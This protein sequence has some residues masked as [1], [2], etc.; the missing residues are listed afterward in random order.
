MLC[1]CRCHATAPV[2]CC[3]RSTST[4]NWSRGLKFVQRINH[5]HLF[6]P[7]HCIR[8]KIRTSSHLIFESCLPNQKRLWNWEFVK[9]KFR[10]LLSLL[11]QP[12]NSVG[13][14]SFTL[15]D[16]DDSNS[17]TESTISASL[18]HNIASKVKPEQAL[19]WVLNL[20]DL[21]SL[22]II[23]RILWYFWKSRSH[24]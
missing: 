19:T 23:Q 20:R 6:D 4:L 16:R 11:S 18:I 3:T 12:Y 8:W 21:Q 9:L 22:L 15:V 14:R 13:Y 1:G 24:G 17:S 7:Q 10:Y 5:L 2:C